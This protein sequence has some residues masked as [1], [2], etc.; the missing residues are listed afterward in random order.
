[1]VALIL[2]F[3]NI[4]LFL[5][6]FIVRKCFLNN[7]LVGRWEGILCDIDDDNFFTECI[8]YISNHDKVCRGFLFYTTKSDGRVVANGVERLDTCNDDEFLPKAWNPTFITEF[9]QTVVSDAID[10]YPMK[11]EYTAVIQARWK[12]YKLCV[13]T[14]TKADRTLRGSWSRL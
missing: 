10:S 2:V 9:H 7:Y 3:I 1:M 8:V 5:S 14:V 11:N 12:K 6:L 4:L 13:T